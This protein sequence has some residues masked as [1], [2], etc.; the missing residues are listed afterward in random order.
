MAHLSNPVVATSLVIDKTK[1]VLMS[2]VRALVEDQYSEW[3]EVRCLSDFRRQTYLI[4]RL[5]AEENNEWHQFL[6][7]PTNI[8]K[9]NIERNIIIEDATMVELHWFVMLQ[10][11]TPKQ[12]PTANPKIHMK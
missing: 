11:V 4:S 9:L 6:T 1:N 10:N 8:D 5:P 12:Q 3:Q 7:A 2:T